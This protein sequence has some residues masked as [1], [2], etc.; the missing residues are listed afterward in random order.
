[1]GHRNSRAE[2]RR[3]RELHRE[4][5]ERWEPIIPPMVP[6]LKRMPLSGLLYNQWEERSPIRIGG[7]SIPNPGRRYRS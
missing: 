1:M 7:P 4:R 2:K 3:R 5:G 6:V